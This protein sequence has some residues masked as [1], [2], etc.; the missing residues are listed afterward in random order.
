MGIPEFPPHLLHAPQP[1]PAQ[2]LLAFLVQSRVS[3]GDGSAQL[4]LSTSKGLEFLSLILCPRNQNAM[5]FHPHHRHRALSV[6]QP[7]GRPQAVTPLCENP[8]AGCLL[9][10]VSALSPAPGGALTFQTYLTDGEMRPGGSS[11]SSEDRP[12]T[13]PFPRPCCV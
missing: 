6:D 7:D 2:L 8:P 11:V 13:W 4:G 9:C 1:P 3:L 10:L 5:S 12:R